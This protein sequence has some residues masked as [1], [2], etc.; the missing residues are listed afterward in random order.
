MAPDGTIWGGELLQVT[1]R[2]WRR[3]AHLRPFPL[4]GGDA[5]IREPRR[6]A[7]GLLYAAFGADAFA[8][9]ELPPVAAFAAKDRAV[10]R[11][12]LDRKVN[13]P[14]TS[15]MGRLFDAFAALC[16]LRQRTRYEGEAAIVFEWAAADGRGGPAL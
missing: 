10:L 9:T 8:R 13:T 4:P 3:A 11:R 2:G 1:E 14:R 12:M 6:A 16:G 5:A 15:S 7:L